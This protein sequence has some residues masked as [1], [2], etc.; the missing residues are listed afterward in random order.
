[1]RGLLAGA[2]YV[3]RGIATFARNPDLWPLGVLPVVLT[4]LFLMVALAVYLAWLPA[5]VPALTPFAEGWAEADRT[6]LRLLVTLLLLVAFGYL[7]ILGFVTLVTVI[8]QP[9]YERI[10]EWMERRL[11]DPPAGERPWWRTLPRAT[12]ESLALLA[13]AVACNA[14]LFLLGFVPLL[15]QTVVPVAAV[16]V[17]GFF[18]ALELMSVPLERRGMGALARARLAWRRRALVGGFGA[19]SFLIFLVPLMNVLAMPGIIV[20][21]TL[22]ARRLTGQRTL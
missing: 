19:V 13:I 10:S 4:F 6:F 12:A 5:L 9:F 16:F 11:G 18:L 14:P 21:A 3:P 7:A 22:L 20:G 17:S 8:G 1:M 15:G 2:A